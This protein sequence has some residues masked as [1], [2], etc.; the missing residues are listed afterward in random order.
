[1]MQGFSGVHSNLIEFYK[2]MDF[3]PN[4]VMRKKL[5]FNYQQNL[6]R[7]FRIKDSAVKKYMLGTK[8]MRQM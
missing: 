8:S 3:H 7:Q 5:I 4:F 6:K 2:Q 1:M